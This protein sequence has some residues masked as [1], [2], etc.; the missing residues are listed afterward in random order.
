[1]NI[2]LFLTPK[3]EVAFLYEDFTIAQALKVMERVRYSSIPICSGGSASWKTA[4]P[5]PTKRPSRASPT[6]R[7]TSR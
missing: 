7:T 6:I 2:L 3:Q 1:M 4:L 5:T